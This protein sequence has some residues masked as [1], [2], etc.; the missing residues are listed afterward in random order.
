MMM[1]GLHLGHPLTMGM[2]RL[3]GCAPWHTLLK[4][5]AIYIANS[6]ARW[7]NLVTVFCVIVKLSGCYELTWP[8]NVTGVD[9]KDLRGPTTSTSSYGSENRTPPELIVGRAS[10][11]APSCRALHQSAS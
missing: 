3:Q 7:R 5:P 8:G 6:L 4:L 11:A 2:P 1:S 10:H 9:A